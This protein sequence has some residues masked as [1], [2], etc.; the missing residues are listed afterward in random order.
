MLLAQTPKRI[1]RIAILDP[2]PEEVRRDLWRYFRDQIRVFGFVEGKDVVYEARSA[3]GA[4]ERLPKLAAELVALKPD[5]IITAETPAAIAA[6]LATT[7]IP[8]V[9]VGVA[10][11][12]ESGLVASLAKPGGNATGT[13]SMSPEIVGKLMEM[14][15]ELVPGLK[16]IAVLVDTSNNASMATFRAAQRASGEIG[17]SVQMLDGRTRDAVE[18]SFET[19]K[20]DQLQGL[21][22]ASAG[23]LTEHRRRIVELAATSRLP[24]IYMRREYVDAGG[25]LS[26]G[27]DVAAVYKRSAD[28]VVRILKGAKPA[29]VPVERPSRFVTVV[30]LRAA[31]S[32]GIRIPESI[33]LRAT[34][35]IE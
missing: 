10:E 8:I 27:F 2:A 26:H 20:R 31:R 7:T 9:F 33:R 30:N 35:V 29:D 23:L 32:L 13:S 28:I 3:R 24:V 11:P 25:L 18:K 1:Y 15:R 34:E 21:I 6:R 22:V 14:F 12:I 4:T 5:V 17:A 16:S 19:I